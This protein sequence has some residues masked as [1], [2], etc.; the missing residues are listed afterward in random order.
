VILEEAYEND[1]PTGE[2]TEL[3]SYTTTP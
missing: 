2:R 1:E 3:V